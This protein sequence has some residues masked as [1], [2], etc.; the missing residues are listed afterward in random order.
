MLKYIHGIRIKIRLIEYPL[1]RVSRF[2]FRVRDSVRVRVIRWTV[3]HTRD[4]RLAQ[5]ANPSIWLRQ[6]STTYFVLIGRSY[7]EL[8]RF[9]A[10][11]FPSQY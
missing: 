4:E 11:S 3:R 7:G 9:M 10:H 6:D 5:N 2:R 8:G 1:S